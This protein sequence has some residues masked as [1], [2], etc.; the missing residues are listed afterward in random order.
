MRGADGD[1]DVFCRTLA[2]EEVVLAARIGHDVLVHLITGDANASRRDNAPEARDGDLGRTATDVDDHASVRLANCK[3]CADGGRHRLFDEAHPTG[4]R[5][6]CG[7]T[8]G[9]LLHFGHARWNAND[10]AWA[11]GEPAPLM[12]LANVVA[13]HLLGHRRVR[14]HPVA[15]WADRHDVTG[16]AP[17]H[18]LRLCAYRKDLA[19]FGLNCDHRW[20]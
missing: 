7:V 19:A 3:S 15:K 10:H 4:T 9:A 8:D 12:H 6:D 5:L 16:G 18:A 17:E 11:G 14:D 2:K 13:D 20:L 1:L